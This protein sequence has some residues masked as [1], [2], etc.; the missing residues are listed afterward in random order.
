MGEWGRDLVSKDGGGRAVGE[1]ARGSSETG[2]WGRVQHESIP[3]TQG[4][5]AWPQSLIYVQELPGPEL[6]LTLDP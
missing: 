5:Q 1:G 2:M 4:L 3:G 6:A